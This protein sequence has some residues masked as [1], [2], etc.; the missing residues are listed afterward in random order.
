[1]ISRNSLLCASTVLLGMVACATPQTADQGVEPGIVSVDGGQLRGVPPR[2]GGAVWSFLGIPYAAP[3][4]GERRWLPPQPAESWTGLRE[5]TALPPGCMQTV[6]PVPEGETPFFGPGATTVQEDCLYLNVWSAAQPGDLA[7]VLVWIHGG[8]LFVGDG[9]EVA[10]DGTSLAER[11]AVV[12]TINY[13]L[14]PFGYLAH[15]LLREESDRGVSGNY[16][17]LDQIAALRW[18]QDNIGQFGGDTAR[19]TIFGESAGSWS[20]NYLMATPLATGLF[21]RAIGQSGGGFGPYAGAVPRDVA[22]EAGRQLASA[23]L[24]PEVPVSLDALRSVS[25]DKLL[26]ASERTTRPNIDGW[27]L[28]DTIY[29]IFAAGKQNDVP[30]IVGANADEG[31]ALRAL[32]GADGITTVDGYR[33]QAHAAYGDLAEQYLEAYPVG[34]DADVEPRLV[35]SLGDGL[36][37]WEMRTWARMMDTVPSP[38]YLYF[39]SR[40]PP[41]PDAEQHG[42]YHTAEIPYVF[43]NLAGG[44]R[45]WY[46]NRD[47]GDV[48][49]Q[50]SEQMSGYWLN[51]AATGDPNGDGLPVWPA[52]TRKDD[53]AMEFG[54]S[55][56]VTR[57]LRA[58][59]LDFF[60]HQYAAHRGRD[61]ATVA[62]DSVQPR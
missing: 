56:H 25:A 2:D 39:F 1:M 8:G 17:V 4:V 10:Y 15:P 62:A 54:D 9:A 32:G 42:A 11:G 5:A 18:V 36:F 61:S 60:D 34:D 40:V 33:A 46:A 53:V 28:P 7:P 13:R 57:G 3:P 43:G 51:F 45:Y 35:D 26:A 29:N 44:S 12:V 47:Y 23:A 6:L 52:H 50:L 48:D 19:V 22:E 21:A 49:Q 27:V 37:V 41:A 14:G 30:V 16:G 38:A 55:V 24:G 59:R 31:T 58:E 20:V